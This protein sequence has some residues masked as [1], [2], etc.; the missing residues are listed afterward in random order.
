M[1]VNSI[2]E[3]ILNSRQKKL[4]AILIDPD[5]NDSVSLEKIMRVAVS[6]G[7]DFFMTGGSLVVSSLDET[8]ISLKKNNSIPIVVFPGNALQVSEKADAL[9][10]ISLISGRNPEFLIGHHVISAPIIKKAGISTIPVG[11]ILIENG[12][13]TSVEY[14]S[15]TVPIPSDKPEIA[16]ATA[17]AGEM[18]GLKAI[19]LEAGSG[20]AQPVGRNLI[21]EV[22]KN[23]S[24]PLIVGGGIKTEQEAL[25]IYRAGADII[26]TGTAVEK[27]PG[28]IAEF[29]QACKS[30]A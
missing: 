23:I 21:A 5:R 26:V 6:S 29:V 19:Y 13:T 9:L 1:Q 30:F 8:I 14:M 27:D 25:D 15:N 17:I 24:I 4:L 10:F 20:A 11:Y 22:R 18:L 28:I 12:R 3:R 7:V 16:V 2:T